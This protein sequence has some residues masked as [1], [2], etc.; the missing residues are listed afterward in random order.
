MKQT[1]L[2]VGGAGYIGSHVNKQLHEAGYQ[3]VVLDN[4]STGDRKS[5]TRGSFIKGDASSSKQLDEIFKSQKIDAVMHFAAF[6][7]IGESVANPYQYYRNNVCHTLNLL[8]AME[9]YKV[10]IFIFSS[11][12]AIFGLPQTNKIAESHPKNPINPYG[13]SKLMVE[14]MLSDAESAYGLRSCALRYFNAAGGDPEG[15]IKNHKKKET[16]LIPILLRSLKSGDHSITIFGTDYPTPDGTCVRDYIHI[17]DLG[18][19]HIR[20]MEQ[21]FNGASSSQYNLGNG[22]GFSVKEVISAVE[23]VTK[24]PVKKIS[25]ERR[26]GDPPLLLA[27]SRKAEQ[28]LGW[29]PR[30]PSLEEM[31]FHAWNSLN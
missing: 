3:T 16:N 11:T 10:D 31:I 24:I 12:A 5:V 8:H 7:D 15:E 25:G 21:L 9:R 18:Q 6:T 13:K 30:F 2:V 19:A 26:L 23:C 1:I 14:Q 27:D 4:L 29:N 20:A 28:E 17:L 22:Q